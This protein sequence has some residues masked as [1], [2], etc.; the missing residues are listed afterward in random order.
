MTHWRSSGAKPRSAWIDGSATFTI[1]MS[2][3]T[4]N[5]TVQRRARAYHIRREATMTAS[6]RFGSIEWRSYSVYF[7]I[8]S[9]RFPDAS[10]R[11]TLRRHGEGVRPVLPDRSRA[12]DR[13]RAVVAAPRA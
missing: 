8:A 9:R 10:W 3:T 5:W 11:A 2:S 4:M 7:Q 6:F 1:A 13:G 12:L